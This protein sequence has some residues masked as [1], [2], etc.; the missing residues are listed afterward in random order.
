MEEMIMNNDT[1]V[2]LNIVLQ[3][4]TMLSQEDAEALE[5]KKAGTGFYKFS[6]RLDKKIF[7]IRARKTY[8]ATQTLNL[9]IDAYNYMTGDEAP[10]FVKPGNWKGLNKKQRLEMH[11][12]RI[13]QSVKGLSFTYTILDS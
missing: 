1:K 12:E 9:S 3:G 7:T 8:D 4:D 10:Y 13:T 6:L 2:R 5:K 11:L